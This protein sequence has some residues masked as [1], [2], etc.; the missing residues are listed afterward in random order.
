MKVCIQVSR[1]W[2]PISDAKVKPAGTG[3]GTM[4]SALWKT[5]RV[6]VEPSRPVA[7]VARACRHQPTAVEV[8]P[9][10]LDLQ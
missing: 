7:G 5:R 2:L 9:D 8:G 4:R 3:L 6:K 1:S 10:S